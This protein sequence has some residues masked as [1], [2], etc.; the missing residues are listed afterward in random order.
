M[1][2]PVADSGDQRPI[3]GNLKEKKKLLAAKVPAKNRP[4][5]IVVIFF[6]RVAVNWNMR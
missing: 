5:T 2:Q 3:P 6:P 4:T 1:V